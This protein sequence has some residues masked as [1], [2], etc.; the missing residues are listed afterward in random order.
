MGAFRAIS[1]KL[2]NTGDVANDTINIKVTSAAITTLE[3]TSPLTGRLQPVDEVSL[4]PKVPGEVKAVYVELGDKVSAGKVLFELD[5]AQMSTAYNKA[6]VTQLDAQ[7][8][9]DRMSKLYSEGAV[10]LQSLEQ[11][12]TQLNMANESLTAA[13]D[14]ISDCSIVSPINGYVT[15]INVAVGSLASQGVPSVTVANVNNL[16]I[17]T[18]ISESMI[19]K[20]KVGD[21]VQVLV[22]SATD[23]PLAGTITTLSPAPAS[24]SLAYPLKVTLN[25]SNEKVK[26]GMFAEVIITSDQKN[27]VIAVPSNSVLVKSGKTKVAV[28]DKKNKVHLNEVEVGIDN[29]KLAEIKS[30]VKA[31]DTIV[32]EG[33][34]YLE[35]NSKIK[36]I[37]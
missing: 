9:Y 3:N 5:K 11:A 21:Q 18:T 13:S 14:A 31:G 19:N 37:E 10:S 26:P 2:E 29:G 12:R 28:V 27:E 25:Q 20:V 32:I 15:A 22:K 30:G 34:Y 35:E 23:K 17:E 24:G 33:Q 7:T 4:V 16:E 6:S 1:A 36:I 8:D